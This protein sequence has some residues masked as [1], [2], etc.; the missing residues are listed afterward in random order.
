MNYLKFVLT[1]CRNPRHVALTFDDGVSDFTN[2][3]LDILFKNQIR[4]TFFVIGETLQLSHTKKRTL[5]RMIREGH[6][7]GS[8][9]FDHPDLR[10]LSRDSISTQ[11]NQ[12]DELIKSVIGVRPRYI[13]PP[14][15]YVN[16]K[17]VSVLRSLGYVIVNWNHDTNDWKFQENYGSILGYVQNEISHPR[18]GTLG[19]IILQHDSLE[20]SIRLQKRIIKIVR[21]KGYEFVTM[22]ECIGEAAYR[23]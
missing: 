20:S 13:R 7:V 4:A 2:D 6:V 17:V 19:P 3:L 8:H 23:Y 12:T 18:P 16:Q 1:G 11:M 21:K 5:I 9:S 10:T 22:P 14:Y 15:G